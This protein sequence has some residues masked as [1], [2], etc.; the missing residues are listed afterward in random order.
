MAIQGNPKCKLQA[1]CFLRLTMSGSSWTLVQQRSSPQQLIA[2][3]R[4]TLRWELLTMPYCFRHQLE[5]ALPCFSAQNPLLLMF[6]LVASLKK[7]G[8]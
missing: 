2:K 7:I 5:A 3:S 1:T 8:M 6:Q 4:S